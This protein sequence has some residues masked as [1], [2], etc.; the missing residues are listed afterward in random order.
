MHGRGRATDVRHIGTHYPMSTSPILPVRFPHYFFDDPAEP[1]LA[2]ACAAVR[3]PIVTAN[4][5]DDHWA[6]PSSRDAFLE[7]R[8][9]PGLA[10]ALYG[11]ESPW[12]MLQRKGRWSPS[13][14]RRRAGLLR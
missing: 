2:D 13:S 12:V 4:A 8:N 1:G 9:A 6:P 11:F 10:F 3:T 14:T 7:N 5:L